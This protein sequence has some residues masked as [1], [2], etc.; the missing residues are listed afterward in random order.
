LTTLTLFTLTMAPASAEEP[1][2]APSRYAPAE[3][4]AGLKPANALPATHVVNPAYPVDGLSMGGALEV[5]CVLS[6][7]VE[8]DGRPSEVLIPE[9]RFCTEV[10]ARNVTEAVLKWRF[11]PPGEPVVVVKSFRYMVRGSGP[12]LTAEQFEYII[13][14][15]REVPAELPYCRMALT[16][17]RKGDISRLETNDRKSCL[18]LPD[19]S[20]PPPRLA[21]LADDE[22]VSCAWAF[23]ATASGP[24][25]FVPLNECPRPHRR[26]S[27]YTLE[28]WLWNAPL[29]S[30]HPY[31]VTVTFGVE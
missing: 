22:A 25:Q 9:P 8:A 3:Q 20:T 2:P 14:A 26:W 13:S 12:R 29:S 15:H 5:Q 21:R 19:L 27:R 6:I 24:I 23:Q 1:P 11:H 10:F 7:R 31:H 17:G 18:V 28:N 4:H 16:I 30:G